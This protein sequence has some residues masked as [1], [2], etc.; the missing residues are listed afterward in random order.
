MALEAREEVKRI[1][2]EREAK[3]NDP[4][5][6]GKH[7]CVVISSMACAD[8]LEECSKKPHMRYVFGA[9]RLERGNTGEFIV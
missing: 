1:R 7:A 6:Y 3:A 2:A 8:D 4:D 9:W 5:R